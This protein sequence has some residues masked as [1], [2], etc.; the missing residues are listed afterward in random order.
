MKTY[1]QILDDT[2]EHDLHNIKPHQS[3]KVM[4]RAAKVY[5]KQWLDRLTKELSKNQGYGSMPPESILDDIKKE[6]DA[7]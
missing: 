4:T 7:Q 6:I 1:E 2:I 5:T 3:K